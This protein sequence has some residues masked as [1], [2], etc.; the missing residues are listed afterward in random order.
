[1]REQYGRDRISVLAAELEAELEAATWP[2]RPSTSGFAAAHRRGYG[3]YEVVGHDDRVRVTNTLEIPFRFVCCLEFVFRHPTTNERTGWRGSGT[4]ISDRH[5][6]TAAHN[7]LRDMSVTDSTFPINYVFPN[8]MLVAP[9]RNDRNFPGNFSEVQTA[10]VSPL[11]QAT[12]N[13]QRTA[14]N[15]VHIEPPRQSDFALLTLRTPLGAREPNAPVGMQLP[16]PPLGF[17]GHPQFGGKTRIR[18]YN[19]AMWHKLRNESLNISGYPGD[20]CR[21]RTLRILTERE[22]DACLKEIPGMEPFVDLGS[23]QWRSYGRIVNPFDPS[24]L[25]SYAIDT[26]AGHS[27][28][29]V[30]LNWEGHRNLVGIHTWALN[31]TANAGVRITEPLL[32]QLRDWMMRLDRVRPTF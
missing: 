5:V 16:A 7:V 30:W 12:A 9:A 22:R 19:T 15:R 14:G 21:H 3:E 29:P 2:Y 24:G 18:A 8:Q 1:M 31:S 6:L 23:T 26:A 27:G 11:W 13:R 4:L 20:K 28:G 17:W 32:R 25:L 10:R